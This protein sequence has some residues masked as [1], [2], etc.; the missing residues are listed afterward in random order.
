MPRGDGRAGQPK[1]YV[2][3]LINPDPKGPAFYKQHPGLA[4]SL[5][6]V[7]GSAREAVADYHDGDYLGMV[8]NGVLAA[9][10]LIP[11]TAVVKGVAKGVKYASYAKT[12][13]N[14][15]N[16]WKWKQSVRPWMGHKKEKLLDKGQHG[17]HWAIPHQ[18]RWGKYV[19]D[20]IKNHPLNI[21]PMKSP[22]MHGRLH[23]PYKKQPPY[24][25]VE[26]YVHG[27]PTW[28]KVGQGGAIGHGG[29]GVKART[30][31]DE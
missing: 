20:Q 1:R 9:S 19:P 5:I 30:E 14:S 27:T 15:E 24:N 4:E 3:K 22:E 21:M 26:R 8:G 11:G 29:M 12:L 7:W 13:K 6:P 31:D 16:A 23:G 2:N 25:A 28:V 10:D 18:E 17:H